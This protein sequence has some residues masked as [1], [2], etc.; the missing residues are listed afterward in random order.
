[1]TQKHMAQATARQV[2]Y[3][4]HLLGRSGYSTEW[5]NARFSRLGATM[6]ERSGRVT[7]WLE[8]MNVVRISDLIGR[9]KKES[10]S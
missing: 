5:M 2:R 1:M 7:D 9:L 8:G 4:L 3:A 6:R 10:Q